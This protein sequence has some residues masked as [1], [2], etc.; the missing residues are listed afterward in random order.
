MTLN[1][2]VHC[3]PLGSDYVVSSLMWN[4]CTFRIENHSMLT[5]NWVRLSTA[6]DDSTWVTHCISFV[7]LQYPNLPIIG[8]T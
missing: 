1:N 6:M 7:I 5:H 3:T 2:C 8:Y 4:N